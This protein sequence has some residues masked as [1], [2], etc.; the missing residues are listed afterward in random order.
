MHFTA[1]AAVSEKRSINLDIIDG[2]L[3]KFNFLTKNPQTDIFASRTGSSR[4]G[5]S[6]SFASLQRNVTS[7]N[8]FVESPAH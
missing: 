2:V 1:G 6:L 3:D 5:R 7:F 8:T 4:G